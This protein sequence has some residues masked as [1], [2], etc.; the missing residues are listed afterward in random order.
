MTSERVDGDN[1]RPALQVELQRA[2]GG[3]KSLKISQSKT[4][5]YWAIRAYNLQRTHDISPT[6]EKFQEAPC[7]VVYGAN[8][9]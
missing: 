9:D 7:D 3:V 1:D 8:K 5:K 4:V 2:I 6:L